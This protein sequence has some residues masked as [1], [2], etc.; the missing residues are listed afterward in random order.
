MLY[1]YVKKTTSCIHVKTIKHAY[2]LI[3]LL[4]CLQKKIGVAAV[5]N[6]LEKAF[7][8]IQLY[9]LCFPILVS[10]PS[11]IY[12]VRKGCFFAASLFHFG[13]VHNTLAFYSQFNALSKIYR[14]L[15]CFVLF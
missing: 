10:L 12:D 3:R 9:T 8:P 4:A 5:K 14:F 11:D 13:R 2:T 15:L 6:I 1:A 7:D